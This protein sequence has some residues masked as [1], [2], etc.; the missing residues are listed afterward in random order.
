MGRVNM[1]VTCI[2]KGEEKEKGAERFLKEIKAEF[3]NLHK[4]LGKQVLK[5]KRTPNCLN[6]KRPSLR[7]TILELS[8]I[9]DKELILKADRDEGDDDN[10]QKHPQSLAADFAA[11]SLQAR[12][13]END[14][15][16]ILKDAKCHLKILYPEILSLRYKGEIKTS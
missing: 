15:L 14:I 11:G 5:T 4:K 6:A 1:R 3:S 10:V 13:E 12:K 9:N 16:K 2:P 7:Q 8:K